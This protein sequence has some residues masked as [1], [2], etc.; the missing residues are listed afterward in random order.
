MRI[1]TGTPQDVE[2]CV[3]YNDGSRSWVVSA[4]RPGDTWWIRV[5][6]VG[7]AYMTAGAVDERALATLE[8]WMRAM[9]WSIAYA[10][11]AR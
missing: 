1:L 3:F 2:A 7:H 11:A 8:H 4:R 5:G 9:H 6:S 10:G